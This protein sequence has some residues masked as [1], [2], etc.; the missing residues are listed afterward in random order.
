M[1]FQYL[2][3]AAA[4]GI[5]AIFCQCENCEKI[6]KKGGK[7]IR[8]R[9]QAIINDDLLI[10]FNADSYI[11]FLNNNIDTSKIK[12][13]L[14]TH[15]HSDHFY[16][17][18]LNMRIPGFA[19]LKDN[20]PLVLYGSEI[21][22]KAIE[23]ELKTTIEQKAVSF[24]EVRENEPFFADGYKIT[25]LKAIHDQN[26]GPLI[27]MI[28]NN[29]KTILYAHDTGL[30]HESVWEYFKKVSPKFNF[31]SL[32]CTQ[33][34][35]EVMGYDAHMNLNDNLKIKAKMLELGYADENTV[36]VSNHFSH[37][38]KAADYDSFKEIAE[39]HGVL[40]SYDGMILEI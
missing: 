6:R 10:D 11:H 22:G 17:D 16:P 31:V 1:K 7:N 12:Y 9:S 5:P 38:G 2:G 39:K 21:A 35:D 29:G 24:T 4:E 15:T 19:H 40:T 23:D 13:C 18:D 28:E 26:S 27:Y 36:F 20:F 33:A 32:D 8:T 14:I 37:N 30:F 25:P 34:A 3:T